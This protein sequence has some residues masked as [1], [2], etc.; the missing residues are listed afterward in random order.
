VQS[1]SS[2]II[3]EYWH[4]TI[5]RSEIKDKLDNCMIWNGP[6]FAMPLVYVVLIIDTAD[7]VYYNL[8]LLFGVFSLLF[9]GIAG[10][11]QLTR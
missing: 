1:F 8:S 11:K 9:V 6:L 7:S 2:I 3:V 4:F 10:K 5:Y